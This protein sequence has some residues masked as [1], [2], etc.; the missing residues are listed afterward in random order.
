MTVDPKD[1]LNLKG[2]QEFARVAREEY[3]LPGMTLGC[4]K[5]AELHREIHPTRIGNSNWYC[6]RDVEEWIASRKQT[7]RYVARSGMRSPASRVSA[8]AK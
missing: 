1:A 3:E 6:R 4:A 8:V 2:Y 7:G 5:Q